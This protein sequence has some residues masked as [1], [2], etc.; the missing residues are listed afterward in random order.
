MAITNRTLAPGTE[1]KAT[2]K[3]VEHRA[4]VVHVY[5]D[6]TKSD[7]YVVRYQMDGVDYK[8]PSAAGSAIFGLD[9]AGKPRTCNGW[10]FWSLVG[11]EG[12]GGIAAPKP[13]PATKGRTR[14]ARAAK[15][16]DAPAPDDEGAQ[17]DVA[18]VECAVCG[19]VFPNSTE[20]SQHFTEA[21]PTAS[22]EGA[23]LVTSEA[24]A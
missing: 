3:G 24:S 22:D 14:G 13:T 7:E 11:G 4:K 10:A 2:Y 8:S 20:A 23:E 16:V 19:D 5:P 18:A 12:K 17:G 15:P 1:L 9:K 21:H 6:A